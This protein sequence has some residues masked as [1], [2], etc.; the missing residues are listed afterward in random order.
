L[1]ESFCFS[2]PGEINTQLKRGDLLAAN[3]SVLEIKYAT[4]SPRA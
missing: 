1:E 3:A 4:C 2:F